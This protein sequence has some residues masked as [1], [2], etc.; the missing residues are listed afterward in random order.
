MIPGVQA[1][2]QRAFVLRS[3]ALLPQLYASRSEV[4]TDQYPGGEILTGGAGS[5]L[6]PIAG[7]DGTF[8]IFIK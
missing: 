3:T 7:V 6:T 8:K 2:D 1:G 4:F 5:N